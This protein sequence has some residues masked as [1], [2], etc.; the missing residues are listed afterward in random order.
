MGQDHPHVSEAVQV[1]LNFVKAVGWKSLYHP[2]SV[3]TGT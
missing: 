2:V 3:S 1:A